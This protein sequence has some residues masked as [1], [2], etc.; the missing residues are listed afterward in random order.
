M[1]KKLIAK[2]QEDTDFRERLKASPRPALKEAIDIDVPNEFNVVVP[3]GRCPHG[4]PAATVS[5]AD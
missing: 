2:S 5:T 3:R 1:M 4:T